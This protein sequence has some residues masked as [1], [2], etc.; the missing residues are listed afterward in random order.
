MMLY[1]VFTPVTLLTLLFL[2]TTAHASQLTGCAAKKQEINTQIS[3]AKKY[4][5]IQRL[6]GLEKALQ[7]ISENCTDESL[8]AERMEKIAEK[9]QKVTERKQD[10]IEAKESGN[11]KKIDKK[12]R[13]LREAMNELQ[14]AKNRLSL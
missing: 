3:Y 12:E 2:S 5:N 7:E 4:G 11:L 6:E 13:K 1:N 14:E 8:K 10:L 9:E